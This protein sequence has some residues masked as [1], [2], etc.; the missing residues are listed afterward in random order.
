M[1]SPTKKTRHLN[2]KEQR[3]MR[4][5][6]DEVR[7]VRTAHSN[8]DWRRQQFLQLQDQLHKATVQASALHATAIADNL[9]VARDKIAQ[10]IE[11]EDY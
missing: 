2:E 11:G 5:T 9:R 6:I 1:A 4:W 8:K 3:N 7:A 10:I